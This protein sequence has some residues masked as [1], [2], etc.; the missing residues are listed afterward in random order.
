MCG[1]GADTIMAK[2]QH[3][4]DTLAEY[5]RAVVRE[6]RA[7]AAERDASAT[8]A[9]TESDAVASAV[10]E[11]GEATDKAASTAH[12]TA[13]EK[14][15]KNKAKKAKNKLA[16]VVDKMLFNYRNIGESALQGLEW[17][18]ALAFWHPLFQMSDASC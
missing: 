9:V 12:K 2:Q 7:L 1:D 11:E 10:V 8:V 17:A 6:M 14:K 4:R 3:M 13:S 5:G 16:H 15:T 18:L